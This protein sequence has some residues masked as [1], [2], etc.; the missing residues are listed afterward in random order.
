MSLIPVFEIGVWNVW[1]IMLYSVLVV[2]IPNLIF[3]RDNLKVEGQRARPRR[4]SVFR[5]LYFMFSSLYTVF[6]CRLKSE[7]SG[8]ML[9]CLF[10]CQD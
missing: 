6:S 8:F 9:V 5:G 10:A 4:S 3:N 7:R 1:I 2:F